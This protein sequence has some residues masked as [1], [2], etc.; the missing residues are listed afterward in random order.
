MHGCRFQQEHWHHHRNHKIGDPD[1]T[2]RAQSRSAHLRL[3]D[4]QE[5]AIGSPAKNCKCDRKSHSQPIDTLLLLDRFRLLRSLLRV[6]LGHRRLRLVLIAMIFLGCRCRSVDEDTHHA[7][8]HHQHAD[9]KER[10][11]LIEGFVE[12]GCQ[13]GIDHRCTTKNDRHDNNR[14][15]FKGQS[16]AHTQCT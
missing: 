7:Q 3:T 14:R 12:V 6:G 4:V 2:E 8:G 16:Q 5:R 10:F 11:D 9:D 15:G 1:A 13:K